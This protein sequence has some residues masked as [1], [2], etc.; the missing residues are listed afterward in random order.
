MATQRK[1]VINKPDDLY[2]TTKG[3]LWDSSLSI[4]SKGFSTL[5]NR[6]ELSSASQSNPG[7]SR[8]H[9]TLLCK[10]FAPLKAHIFCGSFGSVL[11]QFWLSFGSVL[12]QFWLNFSSILTQF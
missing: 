7:M 9:F 1:G 5:D 2:L 3:N 8:L 12:T 4:Q 11:A 10:T 6:I